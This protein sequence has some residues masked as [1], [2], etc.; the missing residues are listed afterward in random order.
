MYSLPHDSGF[1]EGGVGGSVRAQWA[2]KRLGSRTVEVA[3]IDELFKNQWQVLELGMG[4]PG[5]ERL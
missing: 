1:R 4:G 2:E 3:D 5:E